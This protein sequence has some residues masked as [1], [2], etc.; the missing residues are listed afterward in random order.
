[1]GCCS[2]GRNAALLLTGPVL[3]A[4]SLAH[5]NAQTLPPFFVIH[6]AALHLT[7]AALL[8]PPP[9]LAAAA[10]AIPPPSSLYDA[11]DDHA[12]G[13]NPPTADCRGGQGPPPPRARGAYEPRP[14]LNASP[15]LRGDKSLFSASA[16]RI[17]TSM[18][19]RGKREKGIDILLP[20]LLIFP[21]GV[22]LPLLLHC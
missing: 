14:R 6:T 9:S 8:P 2:R 16:I 5:R 1:M 17:W 18:G 15:I 3:P 10:D 12:V 13:R 20:I 11:N 4:H 21:V 7:S 19:K 22:V